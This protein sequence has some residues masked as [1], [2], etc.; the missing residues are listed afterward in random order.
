MADIKLKSD[1]L[2]ELSFEE[3]LELNSD[4]IEE[5]VG[6]IPIPHG[7]YSIRTATCEWKQGTGD[8]KTWR[9]EIPYKLVQVEEV[10]KPETDEE[11][12][13]V[14]FNLEE[15]PEQQI[16]RKEYLFPQSAGMNYFVATWKDIVGGKQIK[17]YPELLS[18]LDLV[19]E[20]GARPDRKDPTRINN[21]IQKVAKS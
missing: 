9:L 5:A 6:F 7:I 14:V 19:V 11:G 17:D 15:M 13:E 4:N 2:K 8:K 21:G 3:M 16:D 18:N 20:I 1:D 10:L 12:N